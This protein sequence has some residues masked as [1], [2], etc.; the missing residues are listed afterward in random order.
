MAGGFSIHPTIEK[1]D[2][3]PQEGVAFLDGWTVADMC[4]RPKVASIV[5]ANLEDWK[6]PE[7]GLRFLVELAVE[8]G[9]VV[10][11]PIQEALAQKKRGLRREALQ[12]VLSRLEHVQ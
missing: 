6:G 5:V 7:S 1:S 2:A 12:E 3:G 4:P 8:M 9:S 11:E 10:R